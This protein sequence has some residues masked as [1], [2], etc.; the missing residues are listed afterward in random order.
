V[1]FLA[2]AAAGAWIDLWS[3]HIAF[4]HLPNDNS[5]EVKVIDGFYSVGRTWNRGIVFGIGQEA[6]PVFLWISVLA[7]PAIVAIFH[8]VKK[9]YWTMTAAL[10]LILGGT[11]GNAYDR[12]R[13][14]AVRDFIKFYYWGGKVWPLFN[15]ADSCICVGVALLTV[16]MLFFDEKKKPAEVPPAPVPAV[17]A[18]TPVPN[19][20]IIDAPKGGA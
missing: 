10:G 9:P 3:K 14:G 18:A 6:G 12:V 8:A 19:D 15:L 11:I 20:P 1:L 17:P 7:V 2:L 13:W 16:E 4:T 5:P